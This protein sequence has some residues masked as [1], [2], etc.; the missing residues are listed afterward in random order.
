MSAKKHSFWLHRFSMLTVLCAVIL[1]CMGGLVTSSEVGLA[2]PDWPTSFGYNMFLL[3][4]DQWLGKAGIFEEHSHRLMAA[5]VGLLTA[6]LAG[7]IWV[8]ETTGTTRIVALSGI[9]LTLGL[10]GVRTQLM[11]VAM[12][13]AAA[14]MSFFC[15]IQLLKNHNSMRWWGTLAYSMVIVQG[16]LG[17]LRVTQLEDQLGI[18]HGALAQIFLVVLAAIALFNSQWWKHSRA[19]KTQSELVPRTV[20]SHF[21]YATLLI[22]LQ[23]IVGATMRHQHAGLPVW[24]FPKAHG[25][26][27]PETNEASLAQYNQQ[28]TS[29]QR[30]LNPDGQAAIFLSTGRDIQARHITMHMSHRV[31]ALFILGLVVGTVILANRKLGAGHVLSKASVFLLGLILIQAALGALT[32]LKYKPADIATLHVLFGA[33]SLGT[34]ALCV[35][36]ARTKELPTQAKAVSS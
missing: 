5:L 7:W 16:V 30:K 15:I 21:F 26:W 9:I 34:G 19:A 33:L 8:R 25:Q 14:A 27:W 6:I 22:F 4:L 28:R 31:I 3:P 13:C 12:A 35:F 20:R 36:V 17:G 2:V 18:F 24:D 29:L 10:M 32:V 23:L 11:F 1:I